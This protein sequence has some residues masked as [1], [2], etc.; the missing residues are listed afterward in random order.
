MNSALVVLLVLLCFSS[1]SARVGETR[2]EFTIRYGKPES[3]NIAEETSIY[4]KGPLFLVAHFFEGKC[5]YLYYARSD[6]DD[7]SDAEMAELRKANSAG[8]AWG[9]PEISAKGEKVWVRADQK[10]AAAHKPTEKVLAFFTE[11]A[12]DRREA[13]RQTKAALKGF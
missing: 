12:L 9:D 4:V 11:D 10:L 7:L 2:E 6:K 1:A 5:D 13:A 8:M 3:V